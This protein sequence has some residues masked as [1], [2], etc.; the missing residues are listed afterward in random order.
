VTPDARVGD[1]LFAAIRAAPHDPALREVYADWLEERGDV[2]G[3]FLRMH[4]EVAPL[5]P[6]HAER[7]TREAEL[8]RLRRG[9]DP[10]WLAVIEPEGVPSSGCACFTTTGVPALHRVPQDTECDGWKKLLDHVE[11]LAAHGGTELSPSALLSAEEWPSIVSLPPTIARLKNVTKLVWYGSHLLRIP[12]E[13]GE[14]SSLQEID[15]YMIYRLH[16]YPYELTRC[17]ALTKSQVSTR[18][19]YGNFK[20][21][22]PF[23]LLEPTLRPGP[24]RPCSVCD[25]PFVDRRR[26]RV[27]ITLRVATDTLPLLVNACSEDCLERLPAPPARYVAGP[28]RGGADV[29]QPET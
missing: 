13:I 5:D 26:H 18:A 25:T 1:E 22:P 12:R 7:P 11:D 21:R 27:W 15:F 2:R 4:A 10:A 8:S 14:M 9:I 29:V 24:V 28:H 17:K 3:P 20:F 19:L 23:P 6:D 16:W